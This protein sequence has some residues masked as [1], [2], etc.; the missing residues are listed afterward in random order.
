MNNNIP[1]MKALFM[2]CFCT[3]LAVVLFASTCQAA[4]FS[5]TWTVTFDPGARTTM[6]LKQ[7]GDSIT[8][9]IEPSD[10]SRRQVE[11]RISGRIMNL[12]RETGLETMQYYRVTIEGD[13]FSG[14]YWNEGKYPGK[15]RFSGNRASIPDV[16]G[17]WS[18]TFDP[19]ARTTM[20][21]KQEGDTVTGTLEP[22]DGSRRQVEGRISGRIMN[23]SRETGLET[24][25]YYRVTIDGNRFSGTYWNEGKYPGKGAFTGMRQ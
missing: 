21:L 9:T 13:R 11:G 19:G 15:G 23:L 20:T 2:A 3:I 1:M 17:T 24:M 22:S 10:G 16:A 8:G 5:G 7:D 4:D 25:Q 6:T 18:V 14:T 12:S